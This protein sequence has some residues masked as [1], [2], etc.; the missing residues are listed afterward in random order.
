MMKKLAALAIAALTINLMVMTSVAARP[1]QDAQAK[2]TKEEKR[3]AKIKELIARLGTGPDAR[4]GVK[5][6]DKTDLAGY[7]SETAGDHFVIT[8]SKTGAVTTVMYSQVEKINLLPSLK[9][10]LKKELS[11]GRFFKRL[12]I[13]AGVVIGAVVVICAASKGCVE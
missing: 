12:A 9:P 11:S 13:A 1:L 3:A 6:R 10:L 5:L 7:V 2:P 4:V 8:N